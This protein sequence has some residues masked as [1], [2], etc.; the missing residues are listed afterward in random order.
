MEDMSLSPR[1]QVM[2]EVSLDREEERSASPVAQRRESQGPLMAPERFSI[3]DTAGVPA[4]AAALEKVQGQ[5]R[6]QGIIANIVD[7]IWNRGIVAIFSS[8]QR[9]LNAARDLLAKPTEDLTTAMNHFASLSAQ[10]QGF[11]GVPITLQ[12]VEQYAAALKTG[13]ILVEVEDE[14]AP[15]GVRL[16]SREPRIESEI[17]ALRFGRLTD[18]LRITDLE[19]LVGGILTGKTP[20]TLLTSAKAVATWN[21]AIQTAGKDLS[22]AEFRGLVTQANANAVANGANREFVE[23][24]T[25]TA[26]AQVDS[27]GQRKFVNE[28]AQEF[29][30][31]VKGIDSAEHDGSSVEALI[32]K[33]DARADKIAEITGGDAT[34]IKQALL[35]SMNAVPGFKEALMEAQDSLKTVVQN[36]QSHEFLAREQIALLGETQDGIIDSVK[37]TIEGSQLKGE[38]AI[39]GTFGPLLVPETTIDTVRQAGHPELLSRGQDGLEGQFVDVAEAANTGFNGHQAQLQTLLTDGNRV[40]V[41]A[42]QERADAALRK[43]GIMN[44]LISDGNKDAPIIEDSDRTWAVNIEATNRPIEDT[45]AGAVAGASREA[46][47]TMI[48]KL[49][50][51]TDEEASP[52]LLAALLGRLGEDGQLAVLGQAFDPRAMFAQVTRDEREVGYKETAMLQFAGQRPESELIA[53]GRPIAALREAIGGIRREQAAAVRE[54][55]ALKMEEARLQREANPTVGM[56]ISKWFSDH[57]PFASRPAS[58]DQVDRVDSEPLLLDLDSL[59]ERD[60]TPAPSFGTRVANFFR[61]LNPFGSKTPAEPELRDHQYSRLVLEE[62]DYGTFGSPSMMPRRRLSESSED[63]FF[64]GQSQTLADRRDETVPLFDVRGSS[65]LEP[66]SYVAA[67]PTTPI[68]TGQGFSLLGEEEDGRGEQY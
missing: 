41:A 62:E 21:Q 36:N 23:A 7:T 50:G 8:E 52:T 57:N 33:V 13:M 48:E 12:N 11:G 18:G 65:L 42:G 14:T 17:E 64:I 27:M 47:L 24:N 3:L 32:A 63:G 16:V 26:W 34:E 35:T 61:G 58:E 28:T 67:R 6:P 38:A 37:S 49:A 10:V 60:V 29:T 1:A 45:S 4:D 44:E 25:V 31:A 56:R 20:M 55:E 30:E 19:G 39:V 22:D 46:F 68:H 5:L 51:T 43:L 15:N 53:D 66:T 54:Q 9:Q 40:A 2:H 59:E